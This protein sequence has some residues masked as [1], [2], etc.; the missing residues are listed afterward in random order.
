MTV[1]ALLALVQSGGTLGVVLFVIWSGGR[2]LWVYG[3][4][5][6]EMRDERDRWRDLALSGT[7]MAERLTDLASSHS[8]FSG[9]RKS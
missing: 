9:P 2:G 6:D 5:Y 4:H 3:S 7:A 1:E 8:G